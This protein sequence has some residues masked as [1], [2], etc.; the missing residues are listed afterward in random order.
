MI[1]S[2]YVIIIKGIN[3]SPYLDGINLN[4]SIDETSKTLSFRLRDFGTIYDDGYFFK[5]FSFYDE[6]NLYSELSTDGH[7]YQGKISGITPSLNGIQ[8][9]LDIEVQDDAFWFG[10][11]TVTEHLSGWYAGNFAL[12]LISDYYSGYSIAEGLFQIGKWIDN[13]SFSQI[14]LDECINQLASMNNFIW[15]VLPGRKLYF[16]DPILLKTSKVYTTEKSCFNILGGTFTPEIDG[17]Q[18]ANRIILNG[19]TSLTEGFYTQ[20]TTLYGGGLAEFETT[21]EPI[22]TNDDES[23][24]FIDD[25]KQTLTANENQTGE[26]IIFYN[27]K[28]KICKLTWEI[29]SSPHLITMVYKYQKPIFV[30]AEDIDSQN[31]YGI[32]EMVV[33]NTDLTDKIIAQKYVDILL[34]KYKEPIVSISFNTNDKDGLNCGTISHLFVTEYG[35]DIDII[36][37]SISLTWI[38]PFFLSISLT[39]GNTKLLVEKEFIELEKRIKRLESQNIRDDMILDKWLFKTDEICLSDLI[40][41]TTFSGDDIYFKVGD[42]L[43]FKQIY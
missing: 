10:K 8:K 1:E 5:T 36:L 42:R 38:P 3:I 24:F 4:F 39:F 12:Q 28:D 9:Y 11:R 6:V 35:F 18:L 26:G 13:I 7:Y 14:K 32:M 23:G 30:Y 16:C 17:S 41:L 25:I 31:K 19:G 34:Q 22:F 33:T 20:E 40:G 37:K 43:G 2:K 27:S 21:Y 29:S 15:G